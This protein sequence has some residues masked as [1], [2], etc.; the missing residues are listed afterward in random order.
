MKIPIKTMIPIIKPQINREKLFSYFNEVLDSGMLT[1]GR[2]IERFEKKLADFLKV[3]Y[4]YAVTS[5]TTALHLALIATGIKIGDEVLVADFSFPATANVVVQVGAKPVFVDIDLKT[6][7]MS[8]ED[9]K[10]KITPKSRA[11]M[12]VHAFGYPAKMAEISQIAKENNLVLIEDAACALGSK[13]LDKFCG[14]WSDAGC[15]SFHPRKVITTGE[16]GAVVTNSDEIAAKIAL[17]RNHGMQKDS[18]GSV[19][20]TEAGYN[21]RMS[22]FQAALGVEQMESF[23]KIETKRKKL[24]DNYLLLLKGAK[25]ITLIEKPSDGINNYQSFVLLLDSK[26]DRT[27]LMAKLLEKGIQTT[28]GTYAQHT[29]PV[30]A[31]FGYKTGDLKN[32]YIAYST[33]LS[34][35]LYASL[36]KEEQ[37]YICQTLKDSLKLNN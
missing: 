27:L 19:E 33:S 4:A 1:G 32:S 18:D 20:F 17:F 28:I 21:Y 14:N 36:T 6:L 3:K 24:A 2:F 35:P 22:E 37:E 5:G 34:L 26:I 11:I 9:L 23:E 25:G 31:K 15:F 13:H 16:G 30:Y 12:V 7:D 8:V 10:N 29:Q